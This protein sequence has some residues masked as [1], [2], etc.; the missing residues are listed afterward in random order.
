VTSPDGAPPELARVRRVWSRRTASEYRSAAIAAQYA[1]W[2]LQLGRSPGLVRQAQRLAADE[3]DHAELCYGLFLAAGGE[4]A[5]TPVP[6][7]WLSLPQEPDRPLLWRA[8]AVAAHEYALSEAVAL[9]VFRHI[10]QLD[11]GPEARPVVDRIVVDEA[12]HA[13]FGWAA[14]DELLAVTGDEGRAFLAERLSGYADQIRAGYR[15]RSGPATAVDQAWGVLGP[16]RY[17]DL[18]DAA[19]AGPVA[20]NLGRL[21][22]AGPA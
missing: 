18:V 21:G 19:L 14:L 12:R 2:L 13:A 4:G 17:A 5:P 9:D 10:Q 3:L 6:D 16:E 11:L 7:L 22:I 15:S 1:W 8:L 20:R